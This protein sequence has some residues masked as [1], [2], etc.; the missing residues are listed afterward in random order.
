MSI[1]ENNIN[2]EQLM[3][4]EKAKV[5]REDPNIDNVFDYNSITDEHKRAVKEVLSV[6][7]KFG[8]DMVADM[9]KMQFGIVARPRYD[10]KD[11]EFIKACQKANILTITQ[12]YVIDNNVEYPVVFIQDDIRKLNEFIE[13]IKTDSY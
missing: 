10:L 7:E 8:Y 12:G 11:S 3:E 1:S 13:K 5:V 9:I 4:D 6:L 2:K